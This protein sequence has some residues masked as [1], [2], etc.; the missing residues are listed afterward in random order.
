M[1]LFATMPDYMKY[2]LFVIAFGGLMLLASVAHCQVTTIGPTHGMVW[3][4]EWPV[5]V[6]PPTIWELAGRRDFG[7][8]IVEDANEQWWVCSQHGCTLIQSNRVIGPPTWTTTHPT[9]T[10][11]VAEWP[12]ELLA[13]KS[14]QST[15]P[16]GNLPYTD[17][18]ANS[19][20]SVKKPVHQRAVAPQDPQAP[21]NKLVFPQDIKNGISKIREE[22]TQALTAAKRR[23]IYDQEA[24]RWKAYEKTHP[25]ATKA[26]PGLPNEGLHELVTV[27][28][29]RKKIGD[30]PHWTCDDSKALHVVTE[31]G[32]HVCVK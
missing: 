20:N 10:Y 19:P 27:P 5:V 13:Q 28:A 21:P 8:Q 30:T 32:E 25:T 15:T 7:T 12:M 4:P 6:T 17:A 29:V 16:T 11:P 14:D 2:A 1:K 24:S 31:A 26:N 3:V 22:H 9:S 23:A 18:G